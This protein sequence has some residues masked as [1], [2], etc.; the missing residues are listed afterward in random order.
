VVDDGVDVVGLRLNTPLVRDVI[1]IGISETR[2]I[3][4]G[5]AEL[6]VAC[7]LSLSV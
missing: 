1:P 7:D 2:A 5:I 4:C 3:V 6:R